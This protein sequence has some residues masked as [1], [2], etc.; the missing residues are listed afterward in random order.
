MRP[1]ITTIVLE[2][3]LEDK[4]NNLIWIDTVKGEVRT[5]EPNK[6]EDAN[7]MLLSDLFRNSFQAMK[8]SPEIRKFADA[9]KK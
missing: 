7:R 6:D 8:S 5:A 4:E 9:L 1:S 2:W 3:K